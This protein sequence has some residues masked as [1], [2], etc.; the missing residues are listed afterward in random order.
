VIPQVQEK[1]MLRCAR[2][3]LL[4]EIGLSLGVDAQEAEKV[5]DEVLALQLPA[6]VPALQPAG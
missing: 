5:L 2:K 1:E 3:P 6:E 4:A